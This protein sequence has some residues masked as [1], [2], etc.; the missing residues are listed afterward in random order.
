[1]K[2]TTVRKTAYC[3]QIIDGSSKQDDLA[4]WSTLEGF[5]SDFCAL[6]PSITSLSLLS[7]NAGCQQSSI[8]YVLLPVV[9]GLCG[10]KVERL[11]HTETQDGSSSIDAH[12]AQG[13]Y[14]CQVYI[15]TGKRVWTGPTK[16]IKALA[17]IG[18]ITNSIVQLFCI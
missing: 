6:F 7:D 13:A 2:Q 8:M 16:V 1:M 18:G 9:A 10:I 15:K 4:V 3:D 5:L 17:F 14:H 12:F 11:V